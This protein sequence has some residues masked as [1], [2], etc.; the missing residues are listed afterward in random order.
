[1]KMRSA[2][3]LSLTLAVCLSSVMVAQ[4]EGSGRGRGGPRGARGGFGGGMGMSMGSALEVLGLLR[5]E[6]VQKEVGLSPEAYKQIQEAMPDLRSL[7][8]ADESERAAKLK[9]ANAKAQD[10]I[11]EALS[12]KQQTRLLGLLVQQQGM[13]AV[14]NEM[15]AKQIGLD[16]AK[17]EEIKAVITKSNEGMRDKMREAFGSGDRNKMREMFEDMRKETDAAIA[18]KLTDAQKKALEELKGDAFTFPERRG[19]GGPGGGDQG[20]GRNRNRGGNDN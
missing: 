7:F 4:D 2:G 19:F 10:L 16:A 8:Q 15:V 13:R 12:P 14:S 11:D 20:G 9:E 6:E 1:M 17:T 5:V 3:M 18:A